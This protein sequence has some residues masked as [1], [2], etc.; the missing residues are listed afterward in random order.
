[1]NDFRSV[2]DVAF[3][4]NISNRKIEVEPVFDFEINEEAVVTLDIKINEY[5]YVIEA[6]INFERTDSNWNYL[7]LKS[8]EAALKIKF[9]PV[10]DLLNGSE[11]IPPK[12]GQLCF[13]YYD[14]GF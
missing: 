8:K 10:I 3:W 9:I 2:I 6:T 4:T 14:I 1:M 12:E 5:G 7:V 11:D 13:V